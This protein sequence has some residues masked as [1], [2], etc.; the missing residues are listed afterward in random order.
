MWA[1]S[2]C[3]DDTNAPFLCRIGPASGHLNRND[4]IG[5]R[6]HGGFAPSFLKIRNITPHKVLGLISYSIYENIMEDFAEQKARKC[7]HVWFGLII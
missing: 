6:T 5:H 7:S 3:G 4:A 2:E 1:T